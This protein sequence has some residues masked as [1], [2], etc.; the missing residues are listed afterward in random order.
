MIQEHCGL[1]VEICLGDVG[2][3]TVLYQ[4]EVI[5]QKETDF[6]GFASVVELLQQKLDNGE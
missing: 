2:E 4:E 6:P 1:T 3:F 5:A